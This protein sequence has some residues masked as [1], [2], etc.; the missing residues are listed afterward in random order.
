MGLLDSSPDV[1]QYF[2][3]MN[4]YDDYYEMLKRRMMTQPPQN[5][6][7]PDRIAH[8]SAQAQPLTM[9]QKP[10][11]PPPSTGSLPPPTPPPM[12]QPPQVKP[13]QQPGFFDQLLGR[14]DLG[15]MNPST[16]LTNAQTNM[17]RSQMFMNLGANLL[18]AGQKLNPQQRAEIFSKLGQ[19]APDAK[20]LSEMALRQQLTNKATREN[21][22]QIDLINT[23]KSPEFQNAFDNM[24]PAYRALAQA[25]ARNGDIDTVEKLIEKSLPEVNNDIV[26]DRQK[27]IVTNLINGQRWDLSGNPIAFQESNSGSGGTSTDTRDVTKYGLPEGTK[28]SDD[29][30]TFSPAYRQK[31]ANMVKGEDVFANTGRGGVRLTAQMQFDAQRA[32]GGD[33]SPVIAQTR[34]D[35][36]KSLA[37]QKQGFLGAY[38]VSVGT[39]ADHL[40]KLA[41]AS[42]N[43]QTAPVL[44]YNR[45]NKIFQTETGDPRYADFATA[46]NV[47]LSELA[48]VLKGGTGVP[49]DSDKAEVAAAFNDIMSKEQLSAGLRRLHELALARVEQTDDTTRRV[50][51][52]F[53]DENKH[54]VLT[55]NAKKKLEE[56][57]KNKWLF[58]EK[59][60]A[61]SNIPQAAIEL[62]KSKPELRAAFDEKYG[63]GAAARILGE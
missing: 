16:G 36:I 13:Q 18:A 27:G 1:T 33:Y 29:F 19:A 12:Q 4:G 20:V 51:G 22:Q 62:L 60:N 30:W 11:V 24:S 6:S 59:N 56:T 17:M 7:V 63:A 61:P 40:N 26:I 25:A 9:L 52:D 28:V 45:A 34:A 31:L 5:Q 38:G 53:Y 35:T 41:H 55:P 42:E 37:N 46:A 3:P 21:A 54:S 50:M 14:V 57:E 47:Y 44:M 39:M 10:Q 43:L 2:G 32:F 49:T 8:W 48:K 15:A 23:M 58:P